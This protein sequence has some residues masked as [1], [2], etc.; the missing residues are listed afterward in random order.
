MLHD[1]GNALLDHYC[2][3]N[4]SEHAVRRSIIDTFSDQ[5]MPEG[6]AHLPIATQ[7]IL[8]EACRNVFDLMV[9]RAHATKMDG[10]DDQE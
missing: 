8:D 9:R 4:V 10:S 3:L 1:E 5:Y 6:R 2:H 7:Y